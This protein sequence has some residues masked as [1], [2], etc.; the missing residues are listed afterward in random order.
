MINNIK[1]FIIFKANPMYRDI[2]INFTGS[3]S[4]TFSF[5]TEFGFCNVNQFYESLIR[6]KLLSFSIPFSFMGAFLQFVFGL[7]PI[8]L[9]AFVTLLTL[10]LISGIFASWIE[11]RKITSKRMK[12]FLMMLFVWLCIL[13]IL[14]GFKQ[15][16]LDTA[17]E[18]IFDYLFTA[19]VLFVNVIYFKSIWE[20]AGRIMD[21]R[22]E[23][24]RLF[25]IFSGK[26]NKDEES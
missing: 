16:F 24:K 19:V 22:E 4:K 6:P 7:K 10:E 9:M 12:A 25:N 8:V 18:P 13:F 14:N 5:I 11:G 21:R 3:M 17:I 23:F 15:H 2:D 1:Y 20:N 26:L